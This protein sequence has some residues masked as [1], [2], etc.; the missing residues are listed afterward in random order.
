MSK[1]MRARSRRAMPFSASKPCWAASTAARAS[2]WVAVGNSAISTP[3]AG[4]TLL[5][6]IADLDS[7]HSP[8]IKSFK[9]P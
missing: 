6:M 2:S 5:L 3:G 7:T 8:P 4:L 1:S 9:R